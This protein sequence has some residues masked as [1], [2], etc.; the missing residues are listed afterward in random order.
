[1]VPDSLYKVSV[2][3]S[4]MLMGE[5][6]VLYNHPA[7]VMAIDRRLT[8]CLKP[9]RDRIINV[10]SALGQ[11]SFSLDENKENFENI[12]NIYDSTLKHKLRFVLTALQSYHT[13]INQGF[14]LIIESEF[15]DSTGFGSSAAV[16]VAVLAVLDKAFNLSACSN[17]SSNSNTHHEQFLTKEEANNLFKKSLEIIRKVQGVGSGMDAASS[18]FGGIVFYQPG[19]NHF[20][21]LDVEG[22]GSLVVIYSGKKTPTPTVIQQVKEYFQDLPQVAENIFNTMHY[23]VLQTKNAILEKN[24]PEV[25]K[26]MNIYHGLMSALQVSNAKLEEL[27]HSLRDLPEITGAKISGAGC[28]DCVIGLRRSTTP[29]S[30][31]ISFP[32][33]SSVNS[34]IGFEGEIPVQLSSQGLR[35]EF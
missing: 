12:E 18:I 11:L 14:D 6:A 7:L 24:W 25:G 15:N 2:P 21:Q 20:E 28:G 34:P 8:V 19:M 29:L 27:V 3:G 13:Q 17:N 1:M 31:S 4:L 10:V 23:C 16:V 32:V 26:M 35:Y 9:G 30:S 33:N 22:M 5:H